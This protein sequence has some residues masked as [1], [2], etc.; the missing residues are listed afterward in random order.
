MPSLPLPSIGRPPAP[1][2]K[3]SLSLFPVS[4]Q[5]QRRRIMFKIVGASGS[6]V[7]RR[8]PAN[9]PVSP[10]ILRLPHRCARPSAH[11]AHPSQTVHY[12]VHTVTVSAHRAPHRPMLPRPPQAMQPAATALRPRRLHPNPSQQ[13]EAARLART[14]AASA[15]LQTAPYPVAQHQICSIVIEPISKHNR[16]QGPDILSRRYDSDTGMLRKIV[17][18]TGQT[19]KL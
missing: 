19:T 11:R 3:S 13:H 18:K 12:T 15:L 1:A 17:S 8:G 6:A 16:K 2:P 4:P 10:R 5:A 14:T 7:A 9:L